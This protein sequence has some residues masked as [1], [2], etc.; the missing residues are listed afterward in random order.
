MTS[1]F[2]VSFW[3]AFGALGC[4][5]AAEA[6]PPAP[7]APPAPPAVEAP[8][9]A[10]TP[11]AP[12]P[13]EEEKKKAL[14]LEELERDRAALRAEHEGELARFTP[15]LR[16]KA[17]ALAQ[18]TYPN[19][20]A[21]LRAVLASEHRKPGNAERDKYR[22]P[23]ETLEF[24][25]FKPTS[26]VIEYGPGE[27]WYTEILA[28]AL[29]KQGKLIITMT[30]PNGPPDQRAT[31]YAERTKYFLD[32]SAEL[33]GS[34]ERIT[35]D[36]K[37]PNLPTEGSADLAL[38]IRGLHGMYNH[39][40]LGTWLREIHDA[41]KPKGVLGIV[42]HRAAPAKTPEET[43]KQAYLPEAW[44]IETVQAAGFKL[45]GKSEVNA[46]PKDT[47]D[48]PEG[49]WALPPSL[50]LGDKDRDKYLAI[51]ES[52]RMTLKFV[53]VAKPEAP[54]AKAQ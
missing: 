6:P 32:R 42:Q 51:G 50:R 54:A 40:T 36:P 18:T 8:P 13:T 21:A 34:V 53:K 17:R 49:V 26:T 9:V 3:V 45:A 47:R 28:P 1:I 31:F 23:L 11:P 43:S 44:V 15:E 4:S 25:G 19:A 38:V 30:D 48:H 22:H 24:F 20:R 39:G 37:A 12:E 52:D 29:A 35:V 14:Q 16:E 41:L 10:E 2:R 33:Y 27:G 7:L 5:R 46:N